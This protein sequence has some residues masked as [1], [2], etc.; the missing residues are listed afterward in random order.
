MRPVRVCIYGGTDLQG[1]PPLF[2]SALAKEFLR[3][4]NP[5]VIVT[6]GYKHSDKTKGA[7]STDAAALDGARAFS[8]NARRSLEQCYEAWIPDPS[9]DRRDEDDVVRMSKSDGI[10]VREMLNRTALGRRLAMVASVDLLVTIAGKKHTEVVVEQALELGV[11]VLPVPDAGGDSKTLLDTYRQRI[12]GSFRRGALDKCLKEVTSHI[13]DDVTTAAR[14]VV[15]LMKTAKVGKCLVLLPYDDDDDYK[16]RYSRYIEPAIEEHMIPDRLDLSPKSEVIHTNFIDSVRSAAAVI[17]DVTID[18]FNVM[19]EIGFARAH[20]LT[21]LL[22]TLKERKPEDMPT[23]IRSMNVR[24]TSEED[25]P[26]LID[27]YLRNIKK[28]RKA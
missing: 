3:E 17:A 4:M 7:K 24:T 20:G 2:I 21:P 22:F 13:D 19:Y 28:I 6:G 8:N 12:A 10:A 23:Y 9:L 27:D 1:A 25:L 26:D 14:A 18:N 11:P 5:C 16:G 15:D